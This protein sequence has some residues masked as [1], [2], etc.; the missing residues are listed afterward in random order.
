MLLKYTFLLRVLESTFLPYSQEAAAMAWVLFLKEQ[1]PEGE[2]SC[3]KVVRI[4]GKSA[5]ASSSLVGSEYVGGALVICRRN[6]VR[7]EPGLPLPYSSSVMVLL[8]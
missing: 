7:L 2:S 8:G 3:A 5:L 1:Y 4:H 6:T